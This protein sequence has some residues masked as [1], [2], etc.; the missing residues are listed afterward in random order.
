MISDT[1]RLHGSFFIGLLDAIDFPVSIEKGRKNSGCYYVLNRT[2]P[3]YLKHSS[4]RKGPWT[5]NFFRSHQ[6]TQL[7]LYEEF[8]ECFTCLICGTDGIVGLSMETLRQ[9]LDDQFE[10]QEYL[11]VRRKLNT[12][13]HVYGRDGEIANRIGRNTIY[14]QIRDCLI[15]HSQ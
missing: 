7:S 5:F 2:T 12:M 9:A 11:I 15:E 8:G 3:V 13:Y 14:Q 1:A 10:E 4:R 6:K